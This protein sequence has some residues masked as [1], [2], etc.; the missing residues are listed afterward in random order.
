M[1]DTTVLFEKLFNKEVSA[2]SNSDHMHGVLCAQNAF[3][4]PLG[5]AAPCVFFFFIS[6]SLCLL[7][8]DFDSFPSVSLIW[9]YTT[10]KELYCS[11]E[12]HLHTSKAL[13]PCKFAGVF[14]FESCIVYRSGTSS[15]ILK[16]FPLKGGVWDEYRAKSTHQ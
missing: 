7:C 3:Y 10:P 12:A 2:I 9:S 11:S 14:C 4:S 13:P 16:V 5:G 6:W 15:F 8:P 1:P